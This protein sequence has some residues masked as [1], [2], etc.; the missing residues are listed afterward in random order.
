V[1]NLGGVL[2]PAADKAAARADIPGPGCDEPAGPASGAILSE[3][4]PLVK[5]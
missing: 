3:Y 1:P 2:L 5:A 4:E